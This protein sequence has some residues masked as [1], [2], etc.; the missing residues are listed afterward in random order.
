[1]WDGR[2]RERERNP[3]QGL[4]LYHSLKL[5]KEVG[6]RSLTRISRAPPRHQRL[7]REVKILKAW[8]CAGE[9]EQTLDPVTEYASGGRCSITELI[10]AAWKRRGPGANSTSV[11]WIVLRPEVYCPRPNL[12]LDGDSNIKGIDFGFTCGWIPVWR[13][14]YVTL[15]LFLELK[16]RS[17]WGGCVEPKS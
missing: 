12:L 1:M 4:L 9:T 5:V 17:P 13:P 15:K 14:L 6:S 10:T 2:E 3:S 16:V 7:F 8:Y 11:G